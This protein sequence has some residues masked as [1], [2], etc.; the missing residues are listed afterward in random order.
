MISAWQRAIGDSVAV[1]VLIARPLA[2]ETV[3]VFLDSTLPRSNGLSGYL[4]GSHP[5][6][7]AE[8]EVREDKNRRLEPFGEIEGARAN[9]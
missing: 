4:N 1:D 9:S 2:T 6:V 7:H 3:Q 8:V 5:E